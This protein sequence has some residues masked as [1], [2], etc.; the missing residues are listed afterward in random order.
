MKR[1][2]VAL[3]IVGFAA[4]AF[5]QAADFTSVDTDQSGAVSWEEVAAAI[6]DAS[7][8]SFRSADVDGSGDLSA[9]E[10][11]AVTGQ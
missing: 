4:P 1:I 11:A 2:L 3:A 7:E 6:P 9:E 10:Y 5:A 8:D